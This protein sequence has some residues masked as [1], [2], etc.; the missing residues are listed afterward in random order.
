M[1]NVD[2]VLFHTPFIKMIKKA[3]HEL[4][5]IDIKLFYIILIIY[6]HYRMIMIFIFKTSRKNTAD[7]SKLKLNNQTKDRLLNK[8]KES[9]SSLELEI[10]N[11]LIDICNDLWNEKVSYIQKYFHEQIIIKN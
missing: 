8:I 7:L 6:C 3:F 9:E 4:V 11:I 5:Y 2:Y 1:F 10:Q